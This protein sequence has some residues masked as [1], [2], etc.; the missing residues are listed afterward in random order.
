MKPWPRTAALEIGSSLV[1]AQ[2][3][4]WRLPA[5][6]T[7]YHTRSQDLQRVAF[8]FERAPRHA[9]TIGRLQPGP[10]LFARDFAR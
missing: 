10:H 5:G 6:Q 9:D 7:R 1:P 4:A 2:T 3:F 8:L